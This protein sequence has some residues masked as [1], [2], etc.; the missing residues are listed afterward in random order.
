M[1]T[2]RRILL[3]GL[4]I[5]LFAG[6]QKDELTADYMTPDSSHELKGAKTS[7]SEGMS[8]IYQ[9]WDQ[10]S[11]SHEIFAY[12]F[13]SKEIKQITYESLTNQGNGRALSPD[14]KKLVFQKRNIPD[15]PI[16][17]IQ[18]T[19]GTLWV[20]SVD[21]AGL[22]Q[23]S[24]KSGQFSQVKWH[25]DSQSIF[26]SFSERIDD[27]FK[28]GIY[29]IWLDDNRTETIIENYDYQVFGLKSKFPVVGFWLSF[30]IDPMGKELIMA[31]KQEGPVI[32]LFCIDLKHKKVKRI[33]ETPDIELKSNIK[34]S[35]DGKYFTFTARVSGII[36]NKLSLMKSNGTGRTALSSL[37]YE[38]WVSEVAFSPNGRFIAF[39]E[40][41]RWSDGNGRIK[42]FDTESNQVVAEE[43]IVNGVARGLQFLEDNNTVVFFQSLDRGINVLLST[44]DTEGTLNQLLEDDMIQ[45]FFSY[46]VIPTSFLY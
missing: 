23:I 5:G 17:D 34:Y 39:T 10:Y 13:D 43:I 4:A 32:D 9:G 46:G 30:D 14:G 20:M 15:A 27:R 18:T 3:I 33:T 44:F 11:Q 22:T 6:C 7:A 36:G 45:S 21:G 25:P 38:A 1:K 28:Q 42:I 29:R 41:Y 8:L 19:I 26:Y 35:P 31:L 16:G 40:W 37:D 12:D 2:L 24:N